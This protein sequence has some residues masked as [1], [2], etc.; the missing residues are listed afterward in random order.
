MISS[1]LIL[2]QLHNTASKIT[3]CG[4]R[5]NRENKTCINL[6]N[7]VLTFSGNHYL[8][9]NTKCAVLSFSGNHYLNNNYNQKPHLPKRAPQTSSFVTF[10]ALS[11]MEMFC[12]FFGSRTLFSYLGEG[13][14][15]LLLVSFITIVVVYV[16]LQTNNDLIIPSFNLQIK[17]LVNSIKKIIIMNEVQQ[18]ASKT[19]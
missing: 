7:V 19:E 5:A 16:A 1:Y 2:V 18:K 6:E 14:A 17:K 11:N 15:C 8:N 9:I 10:S 4:S 3:I 13:R 12:D